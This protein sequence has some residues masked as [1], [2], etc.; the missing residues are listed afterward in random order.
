MKLRQIKS[1]PEKYGLT[2]VLKEAND[3][4]Y[5]NNNK[6]EFSSIKEASEYTGV[7]PSTIIRGCRNNKLYN[8]YK[9]EY[10]S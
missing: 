6:L 1:I 8:E 3:Y 4:A 2:S 5:K 9:F 10:G 7:Y